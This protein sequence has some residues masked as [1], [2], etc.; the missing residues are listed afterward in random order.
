MRKFIFLCSNFPP[1]SSGATPVILNLSRYMPE[2]GWEM[3]PLTVSNPRGLPEDDSLEAELPDGL[4]VSRVYHP[5]PAA[6]LR[7]LRRSEKT[8]E[9][10]AGTA[11][12]S[13]HV[14]MKKLLI[15]DRLITWMPFVVP[16]GVALADEID[17][18]DIVVSF[19]PHHS[20]HIHA[21]MISRL[22]GIPFVAFFGDLW[23]LDSYVNWPSALNRRAQ[24]L[25]ERYVAGQADGI[26]ATTVGSIDYFRKT[27]GAAC[28]PLQV[29]DN[30][31]DPDRPLPP[32]RERDDDLL[33]ITYT[34]NFFAMQSPE[35]I[36]KGLRLFLDQHAEP[37][38]RIRLVGSVQ[39]DFKAEVRELNLGRH[40]EL[41][42][43][44]PFEE[45]SGYQVDSDVLL[46]S[47]CDLPGSEV[48]N[49]S[50]L[51][52]YLKTG[53]PIL[54]IAPEGDM[55]AH[56]RR[57]DAGYIADPSPEGFAGCLELLLADWKAG[58]LNAPADMEAVAETFDAF[59][60]AGRFGRFLDEILAGR[61]MP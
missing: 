34:G 4:R 18:A 27:Y 3:L 6:L 5:D 32:R 52:E 31:Y 46:T 45:V 42:G 55:T 23:L 57:L 59:R 24:A 7:K 60:I 30:G 48:K 9:G 54:A 12:S 16:A 50:K 2:V 37:P 26:A 8:A 22:A 39:D 36:L 51:A 53:R 10:D 47:L 56:V 35:N 41:T 29:V 21:A 43:P 17:G 13:S 11:L 58:S 19:G 33:L 49:S 40:L 1:L 38:L 44:V 28:P 15:P 20:L 14:G 61:A 25:L